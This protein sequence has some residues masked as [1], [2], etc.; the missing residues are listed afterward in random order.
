VCALRQDFRNF[1]LDRVS[2]LELL[3]DH[4]PV[5]AGRTVGDLMRHYEDEARRTRSGDGPE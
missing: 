1:R 4:Y 2:E 5:V 3:D